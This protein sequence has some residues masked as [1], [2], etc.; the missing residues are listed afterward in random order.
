MEYEFKQGSDIHGDL[1]LKTN[2]W[3]LLTLK[4]PAE[5][6]RDLKP[7]EWKEFNLIAKDLEIAI[8]KAFNP[9]LYNWLCFKNAAYLEGNTNAQI[10][11]HVRPRYRKPII[12][13][14]FKFEDTIFGYPPSLKEK[15]IPDELRK[16]IS[17]DSK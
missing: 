14:G 9:D 8:E 17:K 13:E 15:T 7:E 3:K 16:K 6:L 10:H 1:I 4:R 12:F 11:W 2:L 5:N